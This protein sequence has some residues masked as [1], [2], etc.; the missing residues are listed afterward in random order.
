MNAIVRAALPYALAAAVAAGAAWYVQ[1]L[2][3]DVLRA[4]LL[5]AKDRNAI[6]SASNAQCEADV[7]A[8]REAV[9]AIKRAAEERERAA[10]AAVAAAES[11]ASA[12]EQRAADLAD[13]KPAT[14]DQCAA[15][16]AFTLDYLRGRK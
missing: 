3:L 4:E 16:D 12:A 7:K 14:A 1:G 8:T 11:E 15:A 6:L 2:R 10:A 13:Q 5:A 9:F